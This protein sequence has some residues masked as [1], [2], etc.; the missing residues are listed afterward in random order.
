MKRSLIVIAF[1]SLCSISAAA[2]AQGIGVIGGLTWGSV[3]NNNGAL[4]GTL[5]A[6][7]GFAIGLAA[8]SG[9]VVGFGINGLYAQRGF[10][11]STPG[12]SQ[13]LSYIDVPIY[14]KLSIPN[15]AVTP[16]AFVGPQGSFELNCDAAGGT[17]PSGRPKTTF[18]GVIG[19]GLKFGVLG[20]LSV[21]GRYVYGLTNLNLSTVSNAGN[22]QA[23][24]FMLLAGIGF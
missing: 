5:K 18:A 8:E 6:N 7:T 19:A 11:S 22:Y 20:G 2:G 12:A 21:Q 14:I 10:E 4:P 16:F 3:P 17:C 1:A 9:G 13:K 23:R 15:P 24:S